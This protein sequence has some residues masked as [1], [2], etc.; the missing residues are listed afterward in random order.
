MQVLPDHEF[1][2]LII[3]IAVH[4]VNRDM[5]RD[6]T[7]QE[8][9]GHILTINVWCTRGWGACETWSAARWLEASPHYVLMTTFGV[10]LGQREKK[11][12]Q[13]RIGSQLLYEMIHIMGAHLGAG[14]AACMEHPAPP[15][16]RREAPISFMWPP[17]RALMSAPCSTTVDFDQCCFQEGDPSAFG[18]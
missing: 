9:V 2:V 7:I 17:A 11:H 15:V 4:E 14:T 10:Y 6:D 1:I 3:D 8:R 5:T 12:R 18:K 13:L 16:R